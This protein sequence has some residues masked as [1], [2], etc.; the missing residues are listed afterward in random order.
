VLAEAH[1]LISSKVS[2]DTGGG[3]L[4]NPLRLPPKELNTMQHTRIHRIPVRAGAGTGSAVDRV[5]ALG[6]SILVLLIVVVLA[7]VVASR[8]AKK[9]D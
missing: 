9:Q 6:T 1:A 4:P 3:G 2:T 8:K 7:H 5:S